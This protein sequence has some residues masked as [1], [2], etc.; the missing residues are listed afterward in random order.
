MGYLTRY[1]K[2]FTELLDNKPSNLEIT[3]SYHGVYDIFKTTDLNDRD[4]RDLS[5][6]VA[7]FGIGVGYT[8]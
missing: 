7:A 2:D 4:S 1:G 6:F 8:F 5:S 3:F